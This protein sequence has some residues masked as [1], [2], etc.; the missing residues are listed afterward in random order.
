[1]Q[2]KKQNQE[3]LNFQ[4]IL[5]HLLCK[6]PLQSGQ[7][8]TALPKQ[9]HYSW[10]WVNFANQACTQLRNPLATTYFAT[11]AVLHQLGCMTLSCRGVGG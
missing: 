9:L 10:Q 3:S 8:P 6:P 11:Q 5:S 1:M 4:T 7:Q 2:E